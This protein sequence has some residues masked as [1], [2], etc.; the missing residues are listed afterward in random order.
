MFKRLLL[1]E[2]ATL[3]LTVA[4][5]TA[6]TIFLTFLW[7]ALRMSRGQVERFAQLPFTAESSQSSAPRPADTNPKRG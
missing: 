4:F 1:E 6:A 5:V 2:H 3:C 7:H